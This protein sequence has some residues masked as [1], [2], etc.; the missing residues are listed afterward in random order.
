MCQ[1]LSLFLMSADCFNSKSGS[2]S[3]IVRYHG[4]CSGEVYSRRYS[5]EKVGHACS[6]L[7]NLKQIQRYKEA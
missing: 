4:Q 5:A 7:W 2:L 6:E 1:P 3:E